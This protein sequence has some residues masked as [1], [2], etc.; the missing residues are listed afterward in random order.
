MFLTTFFTFFCA[1]LCVTHGCHQGGEPRGCTLYNLLSCLNSRITTSLNAEESSSKRARV[2]VIW[3]R[4]S[5]SGSSRAVYC[6]K[7]GVRHAK[8]QCVGVQAVF[9]IYG[10]FGHF[11]IVCPSART[12]CAAPP[13]SGQIGVLSRGRFSPVQPQKSCVTQSR[14]SF[15][16][17]GFSRFRG[18]SQPRFSGPQ[19]AQ[20]N[21]MLREQAE[22]APEG[23]IAALELR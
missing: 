16:Q 19:Q 14:G 11:A 13:P 4:G 8:M 10:E 12:Q 17:T 7:C 15:Q 21:A 9:H 22:D 6:G 1:Y 5:S 23:V 3:L 20:V 18:S 2:L